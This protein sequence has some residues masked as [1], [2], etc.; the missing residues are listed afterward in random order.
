MIVHILL[1][2][3]AVGQSDLIPILGHI[4]QGEVGIIKTPTIFKGKTSIVIKR[5][6]IKHG[7]HIVVF[8]LLND[9]L[10]SLKVGEI[11]LLNTF[12]TVQELSVLILC[13][14]EMRAK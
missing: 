7:L 4:N 13:T 2:V 10:Q 1:P 12:I 8:H 11:I 5:W 3:L 6:Y 9:W 14:Q